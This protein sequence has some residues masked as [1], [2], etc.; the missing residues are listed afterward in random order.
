MIPL[1]FSGILPYCVGSLWHFIP[2]ILDG[3]RNPA[4][5]DPF[6]SK[7]RRM[8][9]YFLGEE[10]KDE[11]TGYLF[12]EFKKDY[13]EQY[14]TLGI[15]QRARKGKSM[16]FW[17]FVILDGRRVGTDIQFFKEV[18]TKKTLDQS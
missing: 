8:E 15:G 7:D 4:R 1:Y 16:D 18:G 10:D 6:G 5:L 2:F 11:A 12:L 13:P 3:D 17:G 9:Y 14:R